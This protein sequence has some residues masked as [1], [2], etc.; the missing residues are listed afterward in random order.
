MVK[1]HIALLGIKMYA[2]SRRASTISMD[3]LI[4]SSGFVGETQPAVVTE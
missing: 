4:H 3:C 1:T 2:R